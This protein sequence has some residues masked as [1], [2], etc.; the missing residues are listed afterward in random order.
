MLNLVVKI[1]VPYNEG[2]FSYS[3]NYMDI[4]GTL[5]NFL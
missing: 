3:P 1:T 2:I 5:V 4:H